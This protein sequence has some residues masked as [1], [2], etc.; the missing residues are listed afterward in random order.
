MSRASVFLLFSLAVTTIMSGGCH[1]LRKRWNHLV[2]KSE[3]EAVEAIRQDGKR[4]NDIRGNCLQFRVF[5]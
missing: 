5:R 1:D 3:Q 4:T 2:G